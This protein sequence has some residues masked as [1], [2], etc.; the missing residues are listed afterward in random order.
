MIHAKTDKT[1]L[2]MLNELQELFRS[3]E[4]H[5]KSEGR[6]DHKSFIKA[7]RKSNVLFDNDDHHDSHEFITWLLDSIHEECKKLG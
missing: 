4:G 6:F 7:I 2:N 5:K 3:M 1:S